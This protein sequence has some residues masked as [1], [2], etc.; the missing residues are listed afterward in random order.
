MRMNEY[1]SLDDF[2]GE[3]SGN[4]T[5]KYDVVYGI[6][7]KYKDKL[8]RM[9]MDQMESNEIRTQFEAKLNRKLGKYEVAIVDP[10][11][12]TEFKFAEYNFI[13]WYDN[14]YDLLENCY[15]EGKK[16][17]D[18]IMSDETEIIGKD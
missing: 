13:G 1:K 15:I 7:F 16:F 8:Y 5:D 10:S 6:D 12:N 18:V 17:K 3:Y 2:I 14:I 4:R 11:L 9:T